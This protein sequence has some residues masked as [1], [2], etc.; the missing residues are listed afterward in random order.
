MHNEFKHAVQ[1]RCVWVVST[2][3]ARGCSGS[4]LTQVLEFL[5]QV[6]AEKVVFKQRHIMSILEQ[7]PEAT[8]LAPTS[9]ASRD[10]VMH[11]KDKMPAYAD[12]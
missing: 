3:I 12:V 9:C 5:R 2:Q 8:D 4:G 6:D 10:L 11:L 7:L 1:S